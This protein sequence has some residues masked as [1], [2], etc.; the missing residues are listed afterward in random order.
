MVRYKTSDFFMTRIPLM[1]VNDYLSLLDD[2][3][4]SRLGDCLKEAFYNPVLMEALAVASKDL[5]E[6]IDSSKSDGD[7]KS[8][9][10]IRSSLTRYYIRLSTRPTPFGLFSGISIGQFGDETNITVSE[11]HHHTKRARP[12]MEWVYGLIK[13]IESNINIRKSLRVRFNDFTFAN[14]NRIEMPNKTFLQHGEGNENA[15]DISSSIRYTNQ[16]KYIEE[17]YKDFHSFSNILTHMS[18]CNPNIPVERIE[19]FL[20]QL[21][22]NEFLLSEL[23]P[24]LTNT[25]MLDYIIRVLN[26]IDGNNE[27]NDYVMNLKEIQKNIAVYNSTSLGKGIDIYNEIIKQQSGLF[28]CKNYLQVDMKTHTQSNILDYELKNDIE[29]FATA[30][31]R[32]ATPDAVSDEMAHY[33]ELF[34][35]KYGYSAEVPVLELLDIDKGLGTPVHYGISAIGRPVHKQQKP[36]KEERL[37][38]L[39]ERKLILALREG[40][41]TVKITDEDI[42]SVCEGET[43]N[44]ETRPADYHQTFE[45]YLLVHPR[46]RNMSSSEDYCFTIAPMPMSNGLGKSFGRFSDMLTADELTFLNQGFEKQKNILPEHIIAEVTE[47]P[48]TGRVSNV[49]INSSDYDYQIPLATNPCEGKHTLSVRD[50]YIGIDSS[51]NQFFIKSKSLGKKVIVTMTCMMNPTFGSSALRFLREISAMRKNDVTTSITNVI[52]SVKFDYSPRLTYEKVIIRP[53]TWNIS[54]RILGI[55]DEK[56]DYNK[57]AFSKKFAS[58]RQEWKL[59]RYVF[60]NEFDNR[61]MLDLDSPTHVNEIYNVLR[62]DNHIAVTLTE[63]GCNF[64]DYVTVGVD[65][66]NYVTEI[67]LPFVLDIDS[68]KVKS[69]VEKTTDEE[70]IKTH[71]NISANR[72]K[73]D[74]DKLML[75]PG[76]SSWLYYKLYG[77]SKRQNELIAVAYESLEKIV[78]EGIARKY[79]FIR[80]HDPE[81]HLRVRIQPADNM[82]PDLFTNISKWLEGLYDDG[83]ISKA[84]SDSYIRETERYGGPGLIEYAEDYFC[85]DSKLAMSLLTKYRY[86]DL[87]L[88]IDFI[89]VSFIISVFEAFGLSL[90]EQDAVLSL[91]SD[92]KAYRKEFRDNRKMIMRAVDSSD[93]WFEVRSF[94]QN[95]EVYDFISDNTQSLKKLAEA[96]YEYDHKGELTNTVRGIITSVIHMFCNRL[97]GNNTWERKVYALAR[98]GVH[99]LKGFRQHQ[100]NSKIELM[101]PES[102]I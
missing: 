17:K 63:L 44:G 2:Q 60:M 84:V 91:Q 90:E 89:G 6:A 98:H 100:Q 69:R 101:L 70:V 87:R 96:V 1:S 26:V 67:V 9:E 46:N 13:T 37:K 15:R 41:N 85:N 16:V 18:S 77:C 36:I 24:P 78:A 79:F 99:G 49:S 68:V 56:K 23:R 5:H 71:S 61:L 19:N 42:D 76:N 51:S 54:K 21:I 29:R 10:Q 80:Y 92:I 35:E 25:D 53:E 38:A 3:S 14:G 28:K 93:N 39:V 43:L 97:V 50:L 64:E 7:S 22:E 59:P 31:L 102:L 45:L 83:L 52:N 72:L 30:M 55:G 65:R 20:S 33:R 32:L 94:T 12:D 81:P 57:N 48:P 4:Q 47:L 40:K 8:A 74:R 66:K 62:K 58:Y 34:L 75:L 27:V 86:G 88:N 73:L 11:S 82:M 95:P